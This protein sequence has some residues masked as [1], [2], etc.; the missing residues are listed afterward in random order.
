MEKVKKLFEKLK[1]IITP[2]VAFYLFIV[3]FM[4]FLNCGVAISRDY[5]N[6]MSN[7]ITTVVVFLFVAAVLSLI[8]FVIIAKKKGRPSCSPWVMGLILSAST[9]FFQE[10]VI[11]AYAL[12]YKVIFTLSA[13]AFVCMFYLP[14]AFLF[15][16]AK[17]TKVYYIITTVILA[18]YGV[19]QYFVFAFRGAP[20]RAS[21]FNNI[22]SAVEISSEYSITSGFGIAIIIFSLLYLGIAIFSLVYSNVKDGEPKKR[23]GFG[24]AF[25]AVLTLFS[26]F[27]SKLLTY[28]VEN[29]VIKFNFSGNEDLISYQD[30][31]NALLL[32]LDVM[33]SSSPK[34]DGY[35][36][37]KA[38]DILSG[39]APEK[40][41]GE[42]K[43]TVIAI[44]SES[45]ADFQKLGEFETNKDYL[46][47]YHSMKENTIKG[48]VSVSAYGGYSCNSE[49]EFLTGGSMY[50]YPLGSAAYTQYI[51]T[52]QDSLV[53]YFEDRG[54]KTVSMSL[55]SRGLWNTKNV[56]DRMGFDVQ[57]Y[58]NDF[59]FQNLEYVNGNISDKTLFNEIISYYENQK[60]RNPMFLY[61]STAQNHSP[62]RP[63]ETDEIKLKDIKSK[64]AEAYLSGVYETDKAIKT[65]VEYFSKVDEE[66]VIVLYGDHYPHI[67]DF[68]EALLNGTL[69][70]L[71]VEQNAA[72]HSTP[73]FVWANYDIE[74]KEE[75]I[76]LNYLSNTLLEVC[77]APKTDYYLFLDD[78]KKEVPLISAF[79]YKGKDG[80]WRRKGE[81]SEFDEKIHNYGIVQYYRV[82][83]KYSEKK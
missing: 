80:I 66:V 63:S 83:D 69:G 55:F 5:G 57:L 24:C 50:F 58:N 23:I 36:E 8:A 16:K 64:K 19:L 29:R 82:F 1:K 61:A 7:M 38:L 12:K 78:M 72:L 4:F 56:Y 10:T 27:N 77:G 71:S 74:E 35:E 54:Y 45:L 44:L 41:K 20:I 37:G 51:K 28:G 75:D 14:G 33:N 46:P 73:Y 9:Y 3:T 21:D 67:P 32:Y 42:R 31:G 79:G 65:L 22:L 49:F 60:G 39:Y 68:S 62:F 53:N 18:F 11:S 40:E 17:W 59:K 2:S 48:S 81:I 43:P 76:G 30:T 13:F 25:V 15:K 52:P 26:L 70:N 6:H 47:F 34:P